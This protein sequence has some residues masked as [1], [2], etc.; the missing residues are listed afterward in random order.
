MRAIALFMGFW[1][2]CAS[3]VGQSVESVWE[4][5]VSV[6]QTLTEHHSLTAQLSAFRSPEHVERAE[7]S[8][9]VN[10]RITVRTTL[11]TG[12]LLRVGT[13]FEATRRIENRITGQVTHSFSSGIHQVSYR[14]RLE[15][16]MRESGDAMRIR[17]RA[18]V[19]SPLRGE[20]LDPGEPY[21]LLQNEVLGTRNMD[22]ASGSADN[23]ISAHLGWL[24]RN[25]QRIEFGIQHRWEDLGQP[26]DTHVLL[27]STAW[28]FT[29]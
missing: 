8:L 22:S 25:R 11:S 1:G 21:L 17:L 18:S 23:R 27:L 3:A 6:T 7:G 5:A 10:R 28:H 20:R 15:W 16:R 19:R 29:R 24:L 9:F 12:Y 26:G 14:G 2:W 13:P 4:P